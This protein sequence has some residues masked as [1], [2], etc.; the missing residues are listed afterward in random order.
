MNLY[1]SGVCVRACVCGRPFT[2]STM[3]LGRWSSLS[4]VRTMRRSSL[5]VSFSRD[6]RMVQFWER[7]GVTGAK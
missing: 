3:S 7:W 2:C 1:V 6:R 4:I 5:L